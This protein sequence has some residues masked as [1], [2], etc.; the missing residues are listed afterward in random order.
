MSVCPT[1]RHSL[2]LRYSSQTG[3]EDVNCRLSGVATFAVCVC[4]G[5]SVFRQSLGARMDKLLAR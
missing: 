5:K 4:L 3:G 2:V 1:H